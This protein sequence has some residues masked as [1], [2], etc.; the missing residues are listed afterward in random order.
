MS[1]KQ[2][3]GGSNVLFADAPSTNIEADLEERDGILMPRVDPSDIHLVSPE[4]PAY[5]VSPLNKGVKLDSRTQGDLGHQQAVNFLNLPKFAGERR[6]RERWLRELLA[7]YNQ[8]TFR[9]ESTQ[10]ITCAVSQGRGKRAA[11]F[12]MNGQHT[13]W[14]VL[15]LC[16]DDPDFALQGIEYLHYEAANDAAMR[17]LYATIDSGAP[18]TQGNRLVSMLAGRPE[19]ED[20]PKD[21]LR[22]LGEGLSFWLWPTRRS[23]D[24]AKTR[25]SAMTGDYLE[26]TQLVGQF[27]FEDQRNQAK[28]LLRAPVI[29]AMFATFNKA[30]GNGKWSARKF[31]ESVRS[32]ASLEVEDPRMRLFRELL[33]TSLVDRGSAGKKRYSRE[34]LYIVCLYAWNAWREKRTLK[35]SLRVTSKNAVRPEIA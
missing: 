35:Q 12:R 10:I 11:T 34:Q 3:G 20:I 15:N 28:H 17:S 22:R 4:E 14:M 32:G 1:E 27:L 19:F 24:N 2:Q 29:G 9:P 16:K 33:A 31:W 18:R 7:E 6:F 8:G 13:A 21:I 30:P 5:Q 23:G 25:A 26:T